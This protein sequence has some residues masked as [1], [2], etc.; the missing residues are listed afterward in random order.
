MTNKSQPAK[1]LEMD[2]ETLATMYAAGKG[3][4]VIAA[5][6]G[7]P[8]RTG[9]SRLQSKKV[10]ARVAEI[11]QSSAEDIGVSVTLVIEGIS[12]IAFGEFEDTKD[13]LKA[14]ELLGKH[15]GAFTERFE[16]VTDRGH[17]EWVKMMHVVVPKGDADDLS[18]LSAD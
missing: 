4:K 11:L 8:L 1:K 12:E 9:Y 18:F 5:H 17:D 7:I 3:M 14:L 16:D 15:V 13:R 10:K 6:L 2:N